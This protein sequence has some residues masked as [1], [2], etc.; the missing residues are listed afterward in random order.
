MMSGWIF[1]HNEC[2]KVRQKVGLYSTIYHYPKHLFLHKTLW[3]KVYMKDALSIKS[4]FSVPA[5]LL[6]YI[7]IDNKPENIMS[8][9]R[10]ESNLQLQ[11]YISYD[12]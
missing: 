2:L 10:L 12:N 3:N 6:A 5:Y 8:S 9:E 7:S 4:I 1:R 11:L